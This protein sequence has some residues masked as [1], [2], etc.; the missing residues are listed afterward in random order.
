MSEKMVSVQNEIRSGT[1][2]SP[3]LFNYDGHGKLETSGLQSFELD[4][5][6]PSLTTGMRSS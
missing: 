5:V 1:A 4:A 6:R 3:V 2:I